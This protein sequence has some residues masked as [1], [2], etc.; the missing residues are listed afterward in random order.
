MFSFVRGP[1]ARSSVFSKVNGGQK[2]APGAHRQRQRR[3]RPVGKPPWERA[4]CWRNNGST[5]RTI[6]TAVTVAR[7]SRQT[8]SFGCSSRGRSVDK[9]GRAAKCTR[10]PLSPKVQRHCGSIWLCGLGVRTKLC[11][12]TPLPRQGHTFWQVSTPLYRVTLGV[13]IVWPA[14]G[15]SPLF[16]G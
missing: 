1:K 10:R 5:R 13:D 3:D 12:P 2:V 4:A 8:C 6:S 7:P 14:S 9:G 15:R 11:P 16:A